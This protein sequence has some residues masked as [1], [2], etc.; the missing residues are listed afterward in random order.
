MTQPLAAE[1]TAYF[2]AVADRVTDVLGQ[3]LVGLYTTGSL[4]LGDY[5]PGRS[6]IDLAAVASGRVG[7]GKRRELAQLLDHEVLHCPAAGLEFVLYS[8]A[9]VR[10]VTG[11]GG[12][13]LN[14]NTGADLTPLVSLDPQGQP[15]FWYVIDRD[16]ARQSGRALVGPPSDQIFVQASYQRLMSAVMAS[17][18]VHQEQLEAHLLDNTVHNACRSLAF[19]DTARWYAK[20]AGAERMLPTVGVFGQLVR[21]AMTSFQAGRSNSAELPPA[22]IDAFLDMVLGRLTNHMPRR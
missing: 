5:H 8:L 15:A 2:G 9:T 21:A 19:G 22:E 4:A 11:R 13:L 17:V 1:V 10:A 12:Y 16:V 20:L 6:D 3:Q 14:L 7:L 18:Q